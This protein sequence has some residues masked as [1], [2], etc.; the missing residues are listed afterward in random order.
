MIALIFTATS[1]GVLEWFLDADALWG[2]AT[3]ALWLIALAI[4]IIIFI[5]GSILAS[6]TRIGR[7]IGEWFDWFGRLEVYT[8]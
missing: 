7:S 2:F 1:G 6:E 3:F 4:V 5:L 8:A